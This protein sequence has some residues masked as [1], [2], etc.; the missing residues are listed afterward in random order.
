MKPTKINSFLLN[1]KIHTLLAVTVL[2]GFLSGLFYAHSEIV[3][4]CVCTMI[5][6]AAAAW[7]EF[8]FNKNKIV[9]TTT[10]EK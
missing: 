2:T 5:C 8:L 9:E 1:A 4:A 10:M 3:A 6:L 7:C